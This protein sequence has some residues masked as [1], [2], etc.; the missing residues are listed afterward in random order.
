MYR[1]LKMVIFHCYVRLPEGTSNLQRILSFLHISASRGYLADR[2]ETGGHGSRESSCL[3]WKFWCD[4]FCSFEDFQGKEGVVGLLSWQLVGFTKSV[5][6]QKKPPVTKN[7]ANLSSLKLPNIIGPKNWRPVFRVLIDYVSF[8]ECI[9]RTR[10]WFQLFC[11]F[12]PFYLS[13]LSEDALVGGLKYFVF[14]SLPGETI[15][16]D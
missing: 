15:Q 11:C 5:G 10:W 16:F 9:C 6:L 3:C 7:T 2:N 12:H 13:S 14:S 8:R 1:L 4:F